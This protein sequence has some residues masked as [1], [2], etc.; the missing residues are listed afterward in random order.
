MS[1]ACKPQ[2]RKQPCT[3][4]PRVSPCRNLSFL[5]GAERPEDLRLL[6]Q[7]P[8]FNKARSTKKRSWAEGDGRGKELLQPCFEECSQGA[9]EGLWLNEVTHGTAWR[10]PS[11]TSSKRIRHLRAE[12][13]CPLQPSLCCTF[14]SLVGRWSCITLLRNNQIINSSEMVGF[15]FTRFPRKKRK[16]RK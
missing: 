1:P 11:S 6:M 7:R 3:T 5:W 4:R 12:R 15:L 13:V 16:K 9:G 10:Q 2:S 8:S 14:D